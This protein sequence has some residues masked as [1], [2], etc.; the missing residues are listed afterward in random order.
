MIVRSVQGRDGV[1]SKIRR[2][3]MR[4]RYRPRR[5]VRLVAG[6]VEQYLDRITN[7]LGNRSLARKHHVGDAT[8]ILAEQD[9]QKI[10]SEGFYQRREAR[11]VREDDRDIAAVHLHAIA[12]RDQPACNLRRKVA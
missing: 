5:I 8:D 7:D 6:G 9:N 12:A 1:Q 2:R 3:R 4:A 11:D 10:G